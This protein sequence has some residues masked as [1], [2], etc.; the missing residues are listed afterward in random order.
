[1]EAVLDIDKKYIDKKHIKRVELEYGDMEYIIFNLEEKVIDVDGNIY[2]VD[3]K[4]KEITELENKIWEYA[5]FDEYDYWPDKNG[6]HPPMSI[7]WRISFYDESETYYHK[8]GV[9]EYPPKFMELV[10]DLQKLE[11]LK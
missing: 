5:D 9:T 3:I 4:D 6:D 7:L 2:M 8:S 10:K 1:M 11:K